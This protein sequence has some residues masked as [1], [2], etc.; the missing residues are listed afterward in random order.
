MIVPARF[1]NAQHRCTTVVITVFQCG[2]RYG[3]ISMMNAGAGPRKSVRL[4]SHARPKALKVPSRYIDSITPARLQRLT[5]KSAI[6]SEYTGKRA[7]HDM[8]GKI[9]IVARRS[10]RFSI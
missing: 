6:S 2:K 10:R 9:R 4:N 3:G 7:E 8:R 1:K 5:K